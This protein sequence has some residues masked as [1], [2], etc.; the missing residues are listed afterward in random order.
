MVDDGRAARAAAEVARMNAFFPIMRMLGN[1]LAATRP[2]QGWR[3]FEA[4]D[5][6]PDLTALSGDID[7]AMPPEMLAELRELGLV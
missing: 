3:Y 7:P 2:F 1:R 4:K 5:A 6:P